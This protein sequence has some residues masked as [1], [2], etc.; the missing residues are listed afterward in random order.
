MHHP[1]WYLI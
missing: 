1:N